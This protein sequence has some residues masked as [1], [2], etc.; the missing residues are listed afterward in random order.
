[1]GVTQGESGQSIEELDLTSTD[2]GMSELEIC[3]IRVD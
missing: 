3:S 1:V 2:T